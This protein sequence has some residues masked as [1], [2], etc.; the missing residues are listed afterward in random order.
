[1]DRAGAAAESRRAAAGADLPSRAAGPGPGAAADSALQGPAGQRGEPLV[2][3]ALA[4]LT[5]LLTGVTPRL[6]PVLSLLLQLLAG[7]C[8]LAGLDMCSN[9]LWELQESASSYLAPCSS[10]RLVSTGLHSLVRHPLYGGLVLLSFGWAMAGLHARASHRA[11][12]RAGEW[13]FCL[14]F[15]LCRTRRGGAAGEDSSQGER[16]LGSLTSSALSALT[17]SASIILQEYPTYASNK[18]AF[19]PFVY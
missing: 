4:L 8:M 10:H 6:L 7:L 5:V 13:C 3:A 1:V 2:I 18:R 11:L 12:R 17:Q 14:R 15:S 16:H 19:I 9:A